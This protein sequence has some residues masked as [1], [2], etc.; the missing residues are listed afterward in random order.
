MKIA[1][2]NGSHHGRNG[3]TNIMV[4]AFLK[5]AKESGA[6]TVTVFLA[7]K[8]IKY[9][10]ACK[11]CWFKTSG[12]CVIKDDMAEIVSLI[13][14]ADIRVL[15]TPLYFDNISSMLKTFIDRLMVTAS[16]Y[17]GKDSEGECRHLT[18]KA[19]PQLVMLANCG[20]PE[21][22]QFQVISHW[23]KRH[24]RNLNAQIIGEIYVPQGVLLSVREN[25]VGIAV[26]NYLKALET[27]GRE[28]AI[29]RKL[30]SKTQAL[31]EQK[32]IPDEVYIREV[33]KYVDS[34]LVKQDDQ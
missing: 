26:S 19:A 29:D 5:G 23:V 7:E 13:E 9:C 17:W 12:K 16:P 2:I 15:A 3:N 34:L 28:I 22:S 14:D 8:D 24:A 6:E 11:A 27:A 32:F 18:M 4:S 31:L 21:K 10:T 20:F 33:K 1:V 30:T 25:E